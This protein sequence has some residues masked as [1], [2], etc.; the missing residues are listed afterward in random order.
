[1]A[2]P[3]AVV[4]D[5]DTELDALYALPPA[6]FTA[7]RN[8]LA[9]R[10][11]QA[12]QDDASDRVKSLRKPTVPLWAVNQLARRNPKGVAALL[13]SSD[14]LRSA[15]EAALRGSES[16]ALREATSAERGALKELTQ[17]ADELLREAGHTAPGDRVAATLR[18]AALTTEGQ[19][20][21]RQGRLTEELQ[22]SG[23]DAFAG[24]KIPA[25]GAKAKAKAK[26]KETS[27]AQQRRREERW[28]K[29]RER[30]A[31]LREDAAAAAREVAKA[32]A[33]LERARK[34]AE[35]AEQAAGKAE[36]QLEAL[37]EA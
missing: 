37:D 7:A 3:L 1:V 31:K 11:K 30:A 22:S 15:Q 10:L 35:R 23:F 13:D 33:A 19:T 8:D 5:L 20:L 27:P 28:R 36:A 24:M 21:L 17:Q 26:P 32:E 6:E 16:A 25:G 18:A 4:P 14:R 34:D 9:R 12:G 2:K 29:L